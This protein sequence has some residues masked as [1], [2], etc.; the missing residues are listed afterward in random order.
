MAINNQTVRNRRWKI[1]DGGFQIQTENAYIT[2]FYLM[3]VHEGP[4]DRAV[5]TFRP[6][7]APS[8]PRHTFQI[9]E[10]IG[11]WLKLSQ[12]SSKVQPQRLNVQ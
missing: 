2:Y 12:Q 4:L 11:G 10:H 7:T 1:Q 9:R 5:G 6:C 8:L 3:V